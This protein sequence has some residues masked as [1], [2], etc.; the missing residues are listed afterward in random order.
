MPVLLIAAFMLVHSWYDPICC[1]DRDCR[2][3]PA[4]DVLEIEGGWK[5]LPSG[6]IFRDE[7]NIKRIRPSHDSNFHVC[8]GNTPSNMNFP[9]CIYI[10]QGT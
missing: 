4:T 7:P 2:P 8:L 1:S 3:V 10:L 6:A 5:H 9:Y